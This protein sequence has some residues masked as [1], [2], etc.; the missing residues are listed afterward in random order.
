MLTVLH[1]RGVWHQFADRL[2]AAERRE[3]AIAYVA[4]GAEEL[5]KASAG[6][7]VS[8]CDPSRFATFSKALIALVVAGITAD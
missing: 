1:G 2:V 4:A 7:T 6:E 5:L 3:L 8:R